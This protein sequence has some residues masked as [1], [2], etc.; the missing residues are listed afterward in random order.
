M[1]MEDQPV[2]S[3]PHSLYE[4]TRS[5]KR[6]VLESTTTASESGYFQ[7]VNTSPG[8]TRPHSISSRILGSVVRVRVFSGVGSWPVEVSGKATGKPTRNSLLRCAG[9]S[10]STSR[11]SDSP[12]LSGLSEIH[13]ISMPLSFIQAAAESV[14]PS[15]AED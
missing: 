3:Q 5:L 9:M 6:T 12:A 14:W 15:N 1:L 10:F 2:T 7:I 4:S 11:Y 8:F 13:A